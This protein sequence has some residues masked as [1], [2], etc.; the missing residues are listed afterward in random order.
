M[1]WGRG[2]AD[3]RCSCRRRLDPEQGR[4]QRPRSATL[5]S[6]P[7][8]TPLRAGLREPLH[9]QAGLLERLPHQ[10]LGLPRPPTPPRSEPAC[11]VAIVG[12]LFVDATHVP[13]S[14]KLHQL[15]YYDEFVSR[16]SPHLVV[17]VFWVNDFHD[18]F[19][20]LQAY[21]TGG[22]D[23]LPW[24]TQP[25][26]KTALSGFDL[27]LRRDRRQ[28]GEATAS[29]PSA[30]RCRGSRTACVGSGNEPRCRRTPL[31]CSKPRGGRG[32]YI[33][34]FGTSNACATNPGTR[35]GSPIGRTGPTATST[36]SPGLARP[37]SSRVVRKC[38]RIT[39]GAAWRF[40]ESPHWRRP[41]TSRLSTSARTS[42]PGAVAFRTGLAPR[43]PLERHRPSAGRGSALWSGWRR[44]H[45]PDDPG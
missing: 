30:P 5:R 36:C 35:S 43:Q 18:N 24:V 42:C 31:E 26:A 44:L 1:R 20:I 14:D 13:I 23:R 6:P 21:R 2:W 9:Q 17:L 19:P 37:P 15:G 16:T 39:S 3:C 40:T 41:W 38:P 7:G 8:W 12:D 11:R 33:S 10:S 29:G 4:V 45:P 28:R 27:P 34:D 32:R 22:S 25:E